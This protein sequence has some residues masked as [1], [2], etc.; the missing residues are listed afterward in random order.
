MMTMARRAPKT[1]RALV[2]RAN[3]CAAAPSECDDVVPGG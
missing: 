3:G 2:L 1:E